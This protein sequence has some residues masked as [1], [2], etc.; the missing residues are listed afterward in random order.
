MSAWEYYE[1]AGIAIC[2]P[3]LLFTCF[4][5]V[6]SYNLPYNIYISHNK[7]VLWYTRGYIPD[8][9]PRDYGGL[10]ESCTGFNKIY[11]SPKLIY[12]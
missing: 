7:G 6:C 10:V 11:Q 1:Q 2:R 5:L 3:I 12:S 4:L 8:I 9:S